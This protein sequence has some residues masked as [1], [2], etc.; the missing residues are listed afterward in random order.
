MS[1]TAML[2]WVIVYVPDVRAALDFYGRA[3]GLQ[4]VFIDPPASFGQLETGTTALAFA[5]EDR[6]RQEI[7]G[8]FRVGRVGEEPCNVEVCLV[9]DDP[10]AAFDHA[11]ATGCTPVT[12]PV[13]KPHGQ[14]SGFLRDPYGTLIE[15]ASPLNPT[16]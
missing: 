6:A 13:P 5:T 1:R 8:P 12:R 14:T 15:V 7:G 2:G 11:V 4:T 9:F 16:G 3:F 10:V